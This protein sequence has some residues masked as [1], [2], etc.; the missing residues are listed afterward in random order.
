MAAMLK[1]MGVGLDDHR[2][3]EWDLVNYSRKMPV[4]P[5]IKTL[6]IDIAWFY[7]QEVAFSFSPLSS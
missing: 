7:S 4:M 6:A 3:F 5:E 1:L 2:Q